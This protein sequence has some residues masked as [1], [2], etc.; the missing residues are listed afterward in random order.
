[1]HFEGTQL[2]PVLPSSVVHLECVL[3]D[4]ANEEEE[5]EDAFMSPHDDLSCA[6]GRLCNLHR[7]A[8]PLSPEV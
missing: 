5:E 6:L 8:P 1:M 2:P 3:M 4:S 7:S